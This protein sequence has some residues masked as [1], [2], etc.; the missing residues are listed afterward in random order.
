MFP[1]E[2]T[3]EEYLAKSDLVRWLTYPTE[4]GKAPDEIV[5][6]GKI[7][8]LFKKEVFYVFKYRSNSDTLGDDLKNKWL[9]GWS[10]RDGGTFSNFDEFAPF[11]QETAKKTLRL[12]QKKLIG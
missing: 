7:K 1:T 5:Y 11:E 2:C 3:T 6:I 9:I 8:K 10:S 12:I 4:L